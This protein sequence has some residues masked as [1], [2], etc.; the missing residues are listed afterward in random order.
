MDVALER[1]VL[2]W[3]GSTSLAASLFLGG[4]GGGGGGLGLVS[5]RG[6]SGPLS[7]ALEAA[8]V[9]QRGAP[10]DGATGP[11]GPNGLRPNPF[12]ISIDSDS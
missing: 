10:P 2:R 3:A 4:A 12:N 11:L 7:C 5:R 9:G 1:F 8:A 6:R